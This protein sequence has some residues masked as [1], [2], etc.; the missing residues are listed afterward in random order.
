MGGELGSPLVDR[1]VVNGRVQ[2][3]GRAVGDALPFRRVKGQV[4]GHGRRRRV[5]SRLAGHERAG[6]RHR[7]RPA[8]Q[9]PHKSGD[10]MIAHQ[11]SRT[12][13]HQPG[14]P[15]SLRQVPLGPN[16]SDPRQTQSFDGRVLVGHTILGIVYAAPATGRLIEITGILEAASRLANRATPLHDCGVDTTNDD[17]QTDEES[18]SEPNYQVRAVARALRLLTYFGRGREECS[19]ADAAQFLGVQKSTALRILSALQLEH[20]VERS[21]ITGHYRLG[22]RTLEVAAVYLDHLRVEA[23]AAPYLKRLASQTGFTASLGILDGTSVVYIASVEGSQPFAIRASTGV[24]SVAHCSSTGKA[25]LATLEANDLA[26]LYGAEELPV[27]TANSIGTLEALVAEV[28]AIRGRGYA[29]D[30]QETTEGVRCIAAPLR[31]HT[32]RA[33]AAVSVSGLASKL[34]PSLVAATASVVVSSATEISRRMGW[35]REQTDGPPAV[36]EPS[37]RELRSD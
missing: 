6:E 29:I 25:L 37:L 34:N 30:D 4:A 5:G 32:G 2:A 22:V 24:R 8:A 19:L 11:V 1:A 35:P 12:A 27:Y 21:A 10:R 14:G 15:R 20:F 36:G 33:I 26:R 28:A 13:C 23:V 3:L 31:D 7:Y 18:F 9:A 16:R 17:W